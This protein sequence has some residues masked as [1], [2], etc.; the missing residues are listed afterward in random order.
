MSFGLWQSFGVSEFGWKSRKLKLS[1]L[2]S[3]ILK[4]PSFEVSRFLN[5]TLELWNFKTLKLLNLKIENSPKLRNLETHMC[6]ELW[7]WSFRGRSFNFE[8]SFTWKHK[9]KTQTLKLKLWNSNFVI[10][11]F[12]SVAYRNFRSNFQQLLIH[13]FKFCTSFSHDNWLSKNH[14]FCKI[15]VILK[16]KGLL[17]NLSSWVYYFW[18]S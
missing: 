17:Q 4:F 3:W 12:E 16:K 15:T 2:K 18:D 5:E 9:L 6:F 13:N 7:V 1:F 14:K 8:L 10:L 11:K